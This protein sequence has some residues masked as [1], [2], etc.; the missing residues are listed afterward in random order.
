MLRNVHHKVLATRQKEKKII[1]SGF[2]LLGEQTLFVCR[3][4]ASRAGAFPNK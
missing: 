2:Y 4:N 3:V 1:R